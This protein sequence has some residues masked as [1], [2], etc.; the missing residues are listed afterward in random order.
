M[1][2]KAT[3]GSNNSSLGGTRLAPQHKM[4]AAESRQSGFSQES[5]P[6]LEALILIWSLIKYAKEL[7]RAALR[8]EMSEGGSRLQMAPASHRWAR[9]TLSCT[10]HFTSRRDSRCFSLIGDTLM[11]TQSWENPC[12]SGWSSGRCSCGR[13]LELNCLLRPFPTQTVLGFFENYEKCQ[14]NPKFVLSSHP[15]PRAFPP[16]GPACRFIFPGRLATNLSF[17]RCL[18]YLYWEPDWKLLNPAGPGVQPW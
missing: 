14:E 4:Q 12:T 5:V 11:Q 7:L 6:R 17:I 10:Q 18:F 15:P 16:R 3:L 2:G 9:I 1:A 13:G 8:M